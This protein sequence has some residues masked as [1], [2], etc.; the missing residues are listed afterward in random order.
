MHIYVYLVLIKFQR[1]L[2]NNR[3]SFALLISLF[4]KTSEHAT[5]ILS[6]SFVKE[7]N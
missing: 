1:L 3:I 5:F 2:D 7:T 4:A 6:L